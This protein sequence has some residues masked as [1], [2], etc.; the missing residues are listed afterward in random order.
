MF[1][2]EELQAIAEFEVRKLN[3]LDCSLGSLVKTMEGAKKLRNS[4]FPISVNPNCYIYT[5]LSIKKE[6]LTD[7][8]NALG[9]PLEKWSV[10]PPQD[11]RKKEVT[12][13][14]R[15]KEYPHISIHYK[16]KIYKSKKCKLVRRTSSY[17]T[18]ECEV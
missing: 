10:I 2:R 15:C 16:D 11:A 18:M 7:V 8:R 5:T 4:G 12:V 6:Q 17:I 3:D 14:M 13:E 1:N 9:F